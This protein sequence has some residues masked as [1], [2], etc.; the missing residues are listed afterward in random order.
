MGQT[1][2][3]RLFSLATGLLLYLTACQSSPPPPSFA[4]T[5][6]LEEIQ[7]LVAATMAAEAAASAPAP[8]DPEP[9]VDTPS[10]EATATI[11]LTLTST[12]TAL[13]TIPS[14]PETSC[15]PTGTTRELGTVTNVVDGD[16]IDVLIGGETFRVRYIGMDTPERGD[17]Y[18]SEATDKNSQLLQG[19]S[20]TL[21]KDVSE[22]DQFGRILRYVVSGNEFVNYKLVRQG[23]ALASTYT[24]DVACSSAYAEAQNIAASE[25][26][27]LWGIPPTPL[28]T[29]API[30]DQPPT[31]ARSGNCHPSYVGVCLQ[32]G[33]GDYDCAGGSGNGP[34]YV[35]GPFQVIGYDEFGLDRNGDGVGCEG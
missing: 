20:V 11:T 28:P 17:P 22:T 26:L 5:L 19:Q 9:P 32:M 10:P 16:T 3:L 8:T 18:F 13:P 12:H 30:P 23:Y 24:P 21:I 34:N 4:L 25:G 7:S 6:S 31:P 33:I 29:E 2:P 15:I 1:S 14:N 27:G 35:Q